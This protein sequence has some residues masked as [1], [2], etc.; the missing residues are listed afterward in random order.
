MSEQII[1][2]IKMND[3]EMGF[4]RVPAERANNF[5]GLDETQIMYKVLNDE[6]S[7]KLYCGWLSGNNGKVG[8]WK[9]GRLIEEVE[10]EWDEE[11]AEERERAVNERAKELSKR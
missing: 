4:V 10:F 7:R 3:M 6:A 5:V 8:F 11:S 2:K 9:Y 1:L